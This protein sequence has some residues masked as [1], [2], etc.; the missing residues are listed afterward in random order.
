MECAESPKRCRIRVSGLSHSSGFQSP[1]QG[2]NLILSLLK[3]YK[4]R[5]VSRKPGNPGLSPKI[6]LKFLLMGIVKGLQDVGDV[7]SRRK[8]TLE[9]LKWGATVLNGLTTV[10]Q[11]AKGVCLNSFWFRVWLI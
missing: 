8:T 7:M 9:R 11:I 1:F 2:L 3:E 5:K 6:S 10:G 4:F